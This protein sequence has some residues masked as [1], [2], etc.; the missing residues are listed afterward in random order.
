MAKVYRGTQGL[1]TFK[2]IINPETT[3]LFGVNTNTITPSVG[4]PHTWQEFTSKPN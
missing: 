2:S 4:L 1:G 3:N